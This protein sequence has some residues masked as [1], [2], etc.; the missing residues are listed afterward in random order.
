MIWA[1]GCVPLLF[2]TISFLIFC[3]LVSLTFF[4]FFKCL[5]VIALGVSSPCH[6]ALLDPYISS[7]LPIR[8]RLMGHFPWE[9]LPEHLS[10]V[11]PSQFWMD[12][13]TGL[14][15]KWI[16][17]KDLLYSTENSAQCYIS[18]WMGGEFGEEWIHVYAWLS[19]LAGHLKLSQ[20][21]FL[22]SYT[23]IQNKKFK[24][25]K[26]KIFPSPHLLLPHL[27]FPIALLYFFFFL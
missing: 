9:G 20:H 8:F 11:L 16:T 23:L 21:C 3:S 14:H 18:A 6:A 5:R 26:N 7:W 10:K 4:L 15:L 25:A 1:L 19:S 27:L 13:Y 17:S 12:M 24:K 22:I 2:S